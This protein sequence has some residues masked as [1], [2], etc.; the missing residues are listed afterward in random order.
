VEVACDESGY[1]GE[2]LVDTTGEL[3]AHAA[4]RLDQAT[5]T[6]CINELRRRIRSPATE[7]KA[8]HVLRE[9]QRAVLVWLLGPDA[10]LVGHAHVYLVDK[11][12]FVVSRIAELLTDGEDPQRLYDVRRTVDPAL[13][14]AFLITANDLLRRKDRWDRTTPVDSFFHMTDL[15]SG[16]GVPHSLQR[17]QA[18]ALRQR[19]FEDPTLIPPADPLVPAILRAADYGEAIAHDR[20]NTLS[21]ARIDQLKAMSGLTS[22]R[23]V[24]SGTDLR[25]Q[26]ADILAGVIRVIATDELNGTGDPELT[27]LARPYI[28]ERSVWA[29]TASWARLAG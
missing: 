29:D 11:E 26:L 19:L 1:E 14:H 24:S 27:A 28:D 15:L 7:Y 16:N 3:F 12:F 4:V 25:V 21:A 18:E 23:L 5:S 9:K 20:Q 10:P 6:E 17:Q 22:L 8:G 2:K 13:W